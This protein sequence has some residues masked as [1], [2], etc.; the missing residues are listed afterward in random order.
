[1]F[2]PV[3]LSQGELADECDRLKQE[4]A[5]QEIQIVELEYVYHYQHTWWSETYLQC[6]RS[7]Y[8]CTYIYGAG[9]LFK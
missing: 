5:Q 9:A 8:I 6:M 4:N 1:M 7:I 2:V 3:P